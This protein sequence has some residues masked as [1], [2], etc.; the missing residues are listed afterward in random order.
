MNHELGRRMLEVQGTLEVM[1]GS[2][3]MHHRSQLRIFDLD[4]LKGDLT[5]IKPPTFKEE[6][7]K[8]EEVEAWM[9]E[10]RKYLQLHYYS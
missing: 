1:S 9:L 3:I 5:K 4:S 6:H 2:I 8:G 7:K 10:M